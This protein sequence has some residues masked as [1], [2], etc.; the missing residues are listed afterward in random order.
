MRRIIAASLFLSGLPMLAHHSISGAYYTDQRIKVEGTLVEFNLR[1][2]HSF[3]EVSGKDPKTG[4]PTMFN[5]EWGSV[6]RLGRDGISKDSLKPGDRLVLIGNP[7]RKAGDA[8]LHLV[9]VQ[10]K[11]DGWKWGRMAE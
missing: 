8:T 10:R 11:S 9:G 2:P 6:Q 1:D 4:A 7:S 5:I 3:V